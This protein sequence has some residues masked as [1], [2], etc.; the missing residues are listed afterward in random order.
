[1]YIKPHG[2]GQTG[3]YMFPRGQGILPQVG[4]HGKYIKK[5]IRDFA[6]LT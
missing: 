4:P 5:Y 6:L 1:M 3:G 2:E